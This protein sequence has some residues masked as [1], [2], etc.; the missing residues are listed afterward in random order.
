MKHPQK[1]DGGDKPD[2]RVINRQP[3]NGQMDRDR[4]PHKRNY[5][6]ANRGNIQIVTTNVV[7]LP[8]LLHRKSPLYTS[9]F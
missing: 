4:D 1:H 5:V 2:Y 8:V 9:E 6:A 7:E 3:K